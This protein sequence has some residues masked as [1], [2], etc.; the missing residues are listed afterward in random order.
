MTPGSHDPQGLDLAK[1]IAARASGGSPSGVERRPAR[2]RDRKPGDLE[3]VGDLVADVVER[4][5]WSGRI[6]LANVLGR[7]D[8]IVGPVN[9]AHSKPEGYDDRVLTIRADSTAWA[10]SLRQL[11]PNLVAVLNAKLGDGTV[12][13]IVVLGPQAPS[14]KKGRRSV[15]GRGPRDTYG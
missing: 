4:A 5:G 8:D 15:P 7:W 6:A 3:P 12:T 14:W 10:T 9:A 13:R 1:Q 11:A 2:P